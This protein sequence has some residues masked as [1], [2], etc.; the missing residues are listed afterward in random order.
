M[1]RFFHHISLQKLQLEILY[2]QY[3]WRI[4]VQIAERYWNVVNLRHT[5]SSNSPV[6]S[7]SSKE[8]WSMTYVTSTLSADVNQWQA[9]I[10]WRDDEQLDCVIIPAPM[11]ILCLESVPPHGVLILQLGCGNEVTGVSCVCL[12]CFP[13]Y[14]FFIGVYWRT[15]V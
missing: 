6:S 10:S 14:H 7:Q 2:R 3:M 13:P 12:P 1:S 5:C 15:K 4:S 11:F 8:R 9:R